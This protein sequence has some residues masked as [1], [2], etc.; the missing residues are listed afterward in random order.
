MQ[1]TALVGNI[2]VLIARMVLLSLAM[3]GVIGR[4]LV[5]Q[6]RGRRLNIGLCIGKPGHNPRKLRDEEEPY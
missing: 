4:V 2:P 1:R 3:I 6:V 5:M